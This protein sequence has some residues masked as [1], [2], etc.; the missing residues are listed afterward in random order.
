M[1]S[2]RSLFINDVDGVAAATA[3]L[4]FLRFC[5]LLKNEENNLYCPLTAATP[6]N[7][8]IDSIIRSEEGSAIKMLPQ[9]LGL[10][11]PRDWQRQYF[12]T[13]PVQMRPALEKGLFAA[14]TLYRKGYGVQACIFTVAVP[15]GVEIPAAEINGSL[16]VSAVWPLL[17][18]LQIIE[19][20]GIAPMTDKCEF[21]SAAAALKAAFQLASACSTPFILALLDAS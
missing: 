11:Q 4:S 7:S 15:A 2:K 19:E 20:L 17:A 13:D 16:I 12:Y 1:F 8:D 10:Y 14:F 5:Q 3:D 21:E 9:P 6:S 18:K